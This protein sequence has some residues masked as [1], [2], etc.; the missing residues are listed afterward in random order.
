M[1]KGIKIG[2]KVDVLSVQRTG[3]TGTVTGLEGSGRGRKWKVHFDD[4]KDDLFS[5]RSLC[6]HGQGTPALGGDRQKRQAAAVAR[7]VLQAES[8]EESET[9]ST[10]D[11]TSSE[12]SSSD[13]ESSASHEG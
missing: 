12:Q 7:A 4:G 2:S 13:A 1:V 8:E 5:A 9:S 11:E 3:S 10:D 6:L